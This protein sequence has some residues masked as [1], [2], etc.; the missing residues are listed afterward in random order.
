M[1]VPTNHTHFIRKVNK[2]NHFKKS[3]IFS[4][5]YTEENKVSFDFFVLGFNSINNIC[6]YQDNAESSLATDL[7]FNYNVNIFLD[8]EN[9]NKINK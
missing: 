6:Q 7:L 3:E 1:G 5:W 2:N 8:H 9:N 4:K